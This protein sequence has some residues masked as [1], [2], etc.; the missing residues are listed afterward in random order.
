MNTLLKCIP[1]VLFIGCNNAGTQPVTTKDA[2]STNKEKSYFP[3]LDYIKSEIRLVDSL[4]VGIMKYITQNGTTDSGYIKT[5]EF[6]QLAD[7]FLAP[8]LNKETFENKFSESSFFDNTTKYSSFL[9]TADDKS[10]LVQRVDVLARPEDVVYNKVKSVYMEKTFQRSDSSFVQK[11]YWK[12]GQ[13]FQINT[14]I[15]TA[16]PA[17]INTQVKVVWNP[18]Q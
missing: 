12:A 11:L 3:V 5:D 13:N 2:D 6:H 16:R 18:G 8:V 10:L 9:Y 4:P 15:T 14:E 7:E 1:F 17:V